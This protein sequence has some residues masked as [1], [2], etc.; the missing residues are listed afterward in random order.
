[1]WKV[2]CVVAL[3]AQ[4]IIEYRSNT[5]NTK[6]KEKRLPSKYHGYPGLAALNQHVCYGYIILQSVIALFSIPPICMLMID[7][8]IMTTMARRSRS[9]YLFSE[10][11]G[12]DSEKTVV[13]TNMTNQTCHIIYPILCTAPGSSSSHL[14]FNKGNG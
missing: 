8:S 14:L 6:A 11:S 12:P 2:G 1:M 4:T 5:W 7:R 9:F 3:W 13:D 10:D